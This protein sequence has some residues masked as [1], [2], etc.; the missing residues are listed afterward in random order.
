MYKLKKTIKRAVINNG[1][2]TER[3]KTEIEL[4]TKREETRLS[5]P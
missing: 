4:L 5:L 1:R 3:I 2:R